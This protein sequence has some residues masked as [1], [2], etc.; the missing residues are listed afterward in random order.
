M[1]IPLVREHVSALVVV[2][3][4][5]E[6]TLKVEFI[7][8]DALICVIVPLIVTVVLSYTAETLPLNLKFPV[9]EMTTSD[10]LNLTDL[11]ED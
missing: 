8:F 3:S 4:R 11:F 10:E 5:L 7:I 6:Y 2:R 9:S 1:L